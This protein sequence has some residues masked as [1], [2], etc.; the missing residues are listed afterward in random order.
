MSSL[1][2]RSDQPCALK[3]KPNAEQDPLLF[4][5]LRRLR[6][7]EAAEVVREVEGKTPSL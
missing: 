7:E 3:P 5:G 4:P 2:R 6:G 1:D